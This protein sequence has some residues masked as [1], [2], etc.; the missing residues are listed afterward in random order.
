MGCRLNRPKQGPHLGLFPP[1]YGFTVKYPIQVHVFEH[2]VPSCWRGVGRW[3]DLLHVE[4]NC[5]KQAVRLRLEGCREAMFLVPPFY[6]LV[7][8]I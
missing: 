5:C 3:W 7:A 1:R 6:S 2:W 8:L 4:L